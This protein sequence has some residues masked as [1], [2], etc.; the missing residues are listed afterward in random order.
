MGCGV[1]CLDP[2]VCVPDREHFCCKCHCVF[3]L[4]QRISFCDQK[5]LN[6]FLCLAQ[7]FALVSRKYHS[8]HCVFK[9]CRSVI[10]KTNPFPCLADQS[11]F[12]VDFPRNST[13]I[14]V[15]SPNT[16]HVLTPLLWRE[17]E[18][19]RP[20]VIPSWCSSICRVTL[21]SP[22]KL[23]SPQYGHLNVLW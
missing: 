9:E 12:C 4:L 6:P 10:K 21:L 3:S 8:L 7:I 2:K 5:N 22:L 13:S 1:S 20:L 11:S 19:R 23:S 17:R 15:K 18:T 16:N 14:H